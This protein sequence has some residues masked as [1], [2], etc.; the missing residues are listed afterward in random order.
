M[1][2]KITDAIPL[3]V[4]LQGMTEATDINH[5]LLKSGAAPTLLETLKNVET[6]KYFRSLIVRPTRF[7]L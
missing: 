6:L 1:F 3:H 2:T 4:T 5:V 7:L